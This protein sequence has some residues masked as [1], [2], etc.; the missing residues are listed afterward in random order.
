MNNNYNFVCHDCVGNS[1]L[2][3]HIRKHGTRNKC[4]Y[5]GHNKTSILLSDLSEIILDGISI[6]YQNA[7]DILGYDSGEG[8][9]Q[10]ETID[11]W[12]LIKDVYSEE[13]NIENEVLQN[14]IIDS[15]DHTIVWCKKDYYWG[16]EEERAEYSW[17]NFCNLVKH[18]VRYVFYKVEDQVEED[19]SSCSANVMDQ[20]GIYINELNLVHPLNPKYVRIYRGRVHKIGENLSKV[21]DF[22]SP[23]PQ[24]AKASRM[25]SDGIPVFYGAF[26]VETVLQEIYTETAECASVAEFS[27]LRPLYVLNLSRLERNKVPSVFDENKRKYRA[28]YLFLTRFAE[29]VSKKIDGN[30]NIEYIPTQIVSEYFRHVFLDSAGNKLDGIIFPSSKKD[31]GKCIVI[32]IEGKDCVDY[33][34]SEGALFM[35][36][37]KIHRYRKNYQ[38]IIPTGK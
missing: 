34:P 9:Y 29:D 2:K 1:A 30:Y 10:G 5:C 35:D 14:D 12:D 22:S 23:P 21:T 28:P 31:K 4:D 27:L 3:N 6:E 11:T 36:P 17:D 38:I 26:D 20:I 18:K 15:I 32:F 7:A 8:G 13:I 33:S 25:S 19:Y 37:N 24:F 16:T